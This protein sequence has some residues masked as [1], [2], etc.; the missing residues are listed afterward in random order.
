MLDIIHPQRTAN[1]PAMRYLYATTKITKILKSDNTKC[2]SGYTATKAII[3][4]W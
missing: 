1:K 3:H 4:C 2:W